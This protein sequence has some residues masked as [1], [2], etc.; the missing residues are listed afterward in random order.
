M[1]TPRNGMMNRDTE[2]DFLIAVIKEPRQ[3]LL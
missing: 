2:Y 3:A 1:N